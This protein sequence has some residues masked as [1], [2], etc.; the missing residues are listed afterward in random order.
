MKK[1]ARH[2]FQASCPAPISSCPAPISISIPKSTGLH[3]ENPQKAQV[4]VFISRY[5][6]RMNF[7]LLRFYNLVLGNHGRREV[8]QTF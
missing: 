5:L 3:L 1:A 8:G 4:I 6:N 7:G 2:Q